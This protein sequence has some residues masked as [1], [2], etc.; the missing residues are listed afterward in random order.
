MGENAENPKSTVV[1]GDFAKIK[2]QIAPGG[3]GKPERPTR[4]TQLVWG[5]GDAS[6]P[7]GHLLSLLEAGG[8]S[9]SYVYLHAATLVRK[10]FDDHAPPPPDEKKEDDKPPAETGK[11]PLFEWGFDFEFKNKGK[12]DARI[13][14]HPRAYKSGPRPLIV[15]LHGMRTPDNHP[16]LSSKLDRDWT[17]HA[18]KLAQLYI[19]RGS[20]TPLAMAAPTSLTDSKWDTVWDGFDFAAFVDAAVEQ[21]KGLGVEV[22]LAQVAVVGHSAGGCHPSKGVGKIAQSGGTFGGNKLKIIGFCDSCISKGLGENAAKGLK[23]NDT[24][25]IYNVHKGGGGGNHTDGADKYAKAFGATRK[26]ADQ[27]K[28]FESSSIDQYWVSESGPERVSLHLPDGAVFEDEDDWIQSGALGKK[29]SHSA[30]YAKHYAVCLIW[31]RWALQ[32]YFPGKEGERAAAQPPPAEDKG[33]LVTGGEWANVPAGPTLWTPPDSARPV[34][35]EPAVFADPVSAMFWPVRT[36]NQHGRAVCFIGEDGQQYGVATKKGF[37]A[38]GRNFLANRS[39]EKGKRY[40]AGIDIFGDYNDLVVAIESGVVLNFAFFYHGVDRLFVQCDSGVVINYGE[41]DPRSKK[42]FNLTPG[43]RLQA[44]EP[45]ARIGRMTGGS[46]M[47]H[48]ETYPKGTTD[49]VRLW[50]SE[51][52]SKRA[53]VR[54]P[55]QYLLAVAARGK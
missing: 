38:Q 50:A 8:G 29:W 10:R 5:G 6:S 25:I 31:T 51:P 24:T 17:V 41:V 34:S 55:T 4:S 46:S 13:W 39:G 2:V 11:G 27:R 26:A 3:T 18:G 20:V 16:Q 53:L 14:A 54:N 30:G 7:W 36:K 47:L 32:R 43:R 15:Y 52:T 44:G 37:T 12:K 35:T 1:E 42:E 45:I 33:P 49:N 19:D 48:F 9:A 22:D 28:A 40:H 21:L 23:S